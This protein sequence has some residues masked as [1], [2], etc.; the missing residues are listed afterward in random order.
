M[1]SRLFCP[2]GFCLGVCGPTEAGPLAV[3]Y[4]MLVCLGGS[5][6]FGI[7]AGAFAVAGRSGR[8]PSGAGGPSLG[9]GSWGWRWHLRPQ[10]PSG[11][12]ATVSASADTRQ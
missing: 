10:W 6:S 9:S 4:S 1:V 2:I 8:R 7:P 3:V 11:V 12:R 5:R